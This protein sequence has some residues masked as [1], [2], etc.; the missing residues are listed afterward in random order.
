MYSHVMYFS[1]AEII[2]GLVALAILFSYGLQLTAAIDVIWRGVES[3]FSKEKQNQA[4]YMI[5]ALLILCTGSTKINIC[6]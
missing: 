5:R 1:F 4:Y 2:K 6:F 3:K